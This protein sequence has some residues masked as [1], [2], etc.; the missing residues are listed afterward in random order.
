MCDKAGDSILKPSVLALFK[1]ADVFE[2]II[3]GGAI[4]CLLR[5]NILLFMVIKLLSM[6]VGVIF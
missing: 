1:L 6:L 4:T 5:N 2:F 3:E